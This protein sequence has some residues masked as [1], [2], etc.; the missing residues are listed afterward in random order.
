MAIRSRPSWDL[1]RSE[2]DR[3]AKEVKVKN[4]F[5]REQQQARAD[6]AR[7]DAAPHAA[8]R[9][10]L[11]ERAKNMTADQIVAVGRAIDAG[12]TDEALALLARADAALTGDGLICT[13]TLDASNRPIHTF[14][15][16]TGRKDWMREYSAPARLQVVLS[17]DPEWN[18]T[19]LQRYLDENPGTRP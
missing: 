17:K 11:I 5:E 1:S 14:V 7:A 15:S 18:R 4:Y 10:A 13:T 12:A 6:A 19:K 2:I 8:D 3:R 16:V 9:K